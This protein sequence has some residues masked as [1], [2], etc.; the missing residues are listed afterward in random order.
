MRASDQEM[1][2]RLKMKEKADGLIFLG[3]EYEIEA[4][5]NEWVEADLV[6]PEAFAKI[7]FCDAHENEY[8]G[9]RDKSGR[10][11]ADNGKAVKDVV[12]WMPRP[13]PFKKGAADGRI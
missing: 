13:R 7:I 9:I 10:Y 5:G 1:M 4:V 8:F 3:P 11:I 2:R 6:G 12:A